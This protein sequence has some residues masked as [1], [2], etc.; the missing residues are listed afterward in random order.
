ME[1]TK[2]KKQNLASRI[3]YS[4]YS[5]VVVL[6]IVVVCLVTY[7]RYLMRANTL[8][9]FS[10]YTEEFSFFGGTIFTG[11]LVDH[12]GDSK[13]LYTGS[14]MRIYDFESGYYIKYDDEYRPISV[15]KHYE[16]ADDSEEK[17]E[18]KAKA[19]ASLRDIINSTSYS[20]TEMHRDANFLSK[21]NL[22]NLDKLVFRIT[23]H[24]SK[25]ESIEIE[26]PMVVEKVT[27]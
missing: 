24:D 7:A 2:I 9:T 19:A 21:E 25:E 6:M 20:F 8:Y 23:G 3:F 10:G 16:S 18:K 11:P 22:Q 17:D 5:I 27:K 13:V 12:F 4:P 26:I 1:K 14:D 15:I